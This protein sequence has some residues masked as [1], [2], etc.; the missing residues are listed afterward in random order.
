MTFATVLTERLGIRYP[1]IQ[2]PLAGGGDTPELVAAVSEAGGF[3]F[4]GAAYLTPPQIS[5][6]S[7]AVKARTDRPFGVSLFA[8]LRTVEAPKDPGPALARLAPFYAELGLPAPQVPAFR[9][10]SFDEQFAAAL[11]SDASVMSFTFGIL[12]RDAIE[13]TKARGML[14]VGTAT[15]VAE[16]LALERAGV[17]AVVTQGSEAGGHRGTFSGPFEAGMVGTMA[18]VPQVVDAVTVPVIASGGIMD[19]RGIAAA[20]ALGASAVQMG[21]AFL[22]CSEAGIPEVYKAAILA[23]HEDGT[24]LTRAFSGRPARG[25]V[26]RFM[27]DLENPDVQDAILPFPLQN[28]LTRPLRA[29]AAKQGRAEYLSLW[30]GQGLRMAR[31]QSAAD[32]VARLARQTTEALDRLPRTEGRGDGRDGAEQLNG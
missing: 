32:L 30:A 27:N 19:G 8:P 3:G 5:E 18:L 22:T 2:A 1:I 17:D 13:A 15:T 14:L 12:P 20:L 28:A 10:D 31:R 23:S 7:R 11:Q 26:N 25:I 24:R 4:I 6:S 29:A 9:A 16:A 21:T